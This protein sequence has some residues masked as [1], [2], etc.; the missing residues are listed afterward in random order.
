MFILSHFNHEMKF[1]KSLVKQLMNSWVLHKFL[2]SDILRVSCLMSHSS[3]T[4]EIVECIVALLKCVRKRMSICST[5][6]IFFCCR[7]F[8]SGFR[9]ICV[10]SVQQRCKGL[11]HLCSRTSHTIAIFIRKHKRKFLT[12]IKIRFNFRFYSDIR[13]NFCIRCAGPQ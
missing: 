5:C 1:L 13:I 6:H 9:Y 3:W 11:G 12:L 10:Y 4:T 8:F 2:S 7:S